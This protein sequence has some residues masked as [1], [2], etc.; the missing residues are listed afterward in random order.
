MC[1]LVVKVSKKNARFVIYNHLYSRRNSSFSLDELRNELK[2]L[3]GLDIDSISLKYEIKDYLDSGLVIYD[4][5]KY[6]CCME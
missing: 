6:E 4:F 1:Q 5:D 3:Y 2:S